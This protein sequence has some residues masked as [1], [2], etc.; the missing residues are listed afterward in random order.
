MGFEF[1]GAGPESASCFDF[2][3]LRLHWR[4]P[5]SFVLVFADTYD[6]E[7][8]FA[9]R[10][11]IS[12]GVFPQ[13]VL[14]RMREAITRC[15]DTESVRM[16]ATEQALLKAAS[17]LDAQRRMPSQATPL[18]RLDAMQARLDAEWYALLTIQVALANL[19]NGLS[20]D[21]RVRFNAMKFTAH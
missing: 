8:P 2:P 15:Y 7:R 10:F 19:E 9:S 16:A 18:T 3:I 17:D 1:D 13:F 5:T 14:R 21:Q 11:L 20:E 6:A 4:S 12:S